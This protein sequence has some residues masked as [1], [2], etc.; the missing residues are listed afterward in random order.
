MGQFMML[1]DRRG[2]SFVWLKGKTGKEGQKLY[3][4]GF[5]PIKKEIS[6]IMQCML[7]RQQVMSWEKDYLAKSEAL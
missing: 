6:N 7:R 5:N 3:N 1:W 2:G 4:L